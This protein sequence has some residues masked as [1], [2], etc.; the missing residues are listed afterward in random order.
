MSMILKFRK[1]TTRQLIGFDVF[2]YIQGYIYLKPL[3]M[4]DA[5]HYIKQK[6]LEI[7]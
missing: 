4:D 3:K 2:Y 6:K 7:V 5:I 1:R